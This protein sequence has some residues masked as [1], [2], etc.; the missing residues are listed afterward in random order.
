MK[1]SPRAGR[2][3]AV[4]AV[5]SVCS[6]SIAA[7]Y[8]VA[9]EHGDRERHERDHEHEQ[10]PRDF[11]EHEFREREFHDD[12]YL[13]RRYHHDHYYPPRGHVFT[14]LP[15][16]YLALDVGGVRFYFGGGV[17][18]RRHAPGDY[19]V[20][21]PPVGVVLPALP[22]YYTTIR[23]N[24][25]PYYYANDVYYVRVPGG[26]AVVD[27]PQGTVVEQAP[28]TTQP[29]VTSPGVPDSSASQVFVYPK[30]GQSADQQARDRYECHRWA[31]DQSGFDPS[32]S[33]SPATPGRSD[34][35]RRA[36][37]ACLEARGYTVR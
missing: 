22:P 20:V 3:H 29:P 4:L 25:V 6:L 11:H 23:V 26:F 1:R 15:A 28:Q 16:G 7:P 36:I 30:Q 34:D 8:A 21:A 14:A 5:L 27:P 12:R 24:G 10:R 31:V 37:S 19:I 32:T 33:S 2:R 35:Y 9:Q 13:D 18:Y 17:W